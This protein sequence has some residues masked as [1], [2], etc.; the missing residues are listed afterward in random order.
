MESGISLHDKGK[1]AEEVPYTSIQQSTPLAAHVINNFASSPYVS[2]SYEVIEA[3]FA[4]NVLQ[5]QKVILFEKHVQDF[6]ASENAVLLAHI[7]DKF[8]EI[9]DHSKTPFIPQNP[10]NRSILEKL[11]HLGIIRI[12]PE[13]RNHYQVFH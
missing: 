6:D 8:G 2:R 1:L 5:E 4:Q 12:F 11:Q 3:L 10:V 9:I 13:N 7:G